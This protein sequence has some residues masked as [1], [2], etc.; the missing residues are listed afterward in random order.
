MKLNILSDLHVGYSALDTPL[1][2]ADVVVL[3]GDVAAP[4]QAAQWAMRL[5]K[6]VIYV[7]GNHEFYG[8][9]IDAAAAE[10]KRLCAGTHIH[11]LD[12]DEVIIDGVRFLGSTLWTDFM[13]FGDG[14]ERTAAIVEA[15]RLMRDFSR[16]R[17]DT[18]TGALFTPDDSA[19]LFQ[20]NAKWLNR[21]LDTPHA[22]TTVVVTHHAPS[23]RSIHPRFAASLLNACFVS[24]AERVAGAGRAQWWIHGHTHDSFDYVLNGTRVICNPRG[25]AK[26]G[27]N[28]NARFDPDFTIEV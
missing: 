20:R 18:A 3:A 28:E 7:L 26:A 22:G 16:I 17:M 6:P 2:D 10:M 12:N 4:R 9:S 13:L 27:V 24:D 1:N 23:R 8:S 15:Q 19:A 21:C 11:V 25:Y 5:D 14:T